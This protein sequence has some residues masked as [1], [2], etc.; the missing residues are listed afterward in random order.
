MYEAHLI[1]N[2]QTFAVWCPCKCKSITEALYL[3]DDSFCSHVPKF[4]DAITAYTAKLRVLRGIKG[5]L[6]NGSSMT[7][8]F[9][10]V[11][12]VL[13]VGVPSTEINDRAT[14][15]GI[16]STYTLNVR[17]AAPVAMSVPSGFQ[18]ILRML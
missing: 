13:P 14:K 2:D 4:D 9:S 3:V 10:R 12:D 5:N 16:A 8:Q 17:S 6:F 7:F 18:A 1:S 11:L 15:A